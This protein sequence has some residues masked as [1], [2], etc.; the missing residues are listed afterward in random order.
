MNHKKWDDSIFGAARYLA[1]TLGVKLENATAGTIDEVMSASQ[2]KE[3]WRQATF[4]CRCSTN[5]DQ[6]TFDNRAFCL[7]CSFII[8]HNSVPDIQRCPG[9]LINNSWENIG[10][11]CLA[12]QFATIIY[13]NRFSDR[14]KKY[15]QIWLPPLETDTDVDSETYY[16]STPCSAQHTQESHEELYR[17]R[18]QS[19]S[20]S[21]QEIKSRS[22]H[23]QTKYVFEN[24]SLLQKNIQNNCGALKR[25]HNSQLSDSL[26]SEPGNNENLYP[27]QLYSSRKKLFLKIPVKAIPDDSST[28]L[29]NNDSRPPLRNLELNLLDNASEQSHNTSARKNRKQS[30]ILRAKALKP[31]GCP[32]SIP[33]N[34]ETL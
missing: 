34:A 7:K 3:K 12:C 11:S 1:N 26:T 16:K 25:D 6:Q 13:R 10:Q 32:D 22:S 29:T 15:L 23:Q 33:P 21:F 19:L 5:H 17:L 27:T 30:R 4:S 14:Y 8:Y 20:D 24:L 31:K 18:N 28:S 9:C 2:I